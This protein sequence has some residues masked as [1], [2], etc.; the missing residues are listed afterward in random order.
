[1]VGKF[2]FERGRQ[3]ASGNLAIKDHSGSIILQPLYRETAFLAGLAK[4][5]FSMEAPVETVLDRLVPRIFAESS[6]CSF[7]TL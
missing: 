7:S 2:N 3:S 4:N 1:M 6:S 5:Q